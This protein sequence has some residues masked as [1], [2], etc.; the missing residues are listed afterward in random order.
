[1]TA[2]TEHGAMR[3]S[4]ED[5]L[6]GHPLAPQEPGAQAYKASWVVAL[7]DG[8]DA[9]GRRGDA[10]EAT[11]PGRRPGRDVCARNETEDG[12]WHHRRSGGRHLCVASHSDPPE[13]TSFLAQGTGYWTRAASGRSPMP[14]ATCCRAS[15]WQR[16]KMCASPAAPST[17]ASRLVIQSAGISWFRAWLMSPYPRCRPGAVHR[18]RRQ[19]PGTGGQ[20]GH[21]RRDRARRRAGPLP[22]G[23][24]GATR[25]AGLV[26]GASAG[27]GG[28]SR[29][30]TVGSVPDGRRR[31]VL[32]RPLEINRLAT[33][34]IGGAMGEQVNA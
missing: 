20:R 19:R 7:D 3:L 17:A 12:T 11:A 22:T 29:P 24:S 16:L 18:P 25:P 5:G 2:V 27:S 26:P 23:G 28:V 21:R 9:G 31:G 1:M 14:R 10:D 13:V 33:T 6:Q 8:L 34:R 4:P 15:R 32:D 30:A